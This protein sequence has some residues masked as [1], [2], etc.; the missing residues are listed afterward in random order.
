[1]NRYEALYRKG[2]RALVA[3]FAAWLGLMLI[4]WALPVR[5]Q[6]SDLIWG[7]IAVWFVALFVFITVWSIITMVSY[8]RWTG[9]YPYYFLF[10][11]SHDLNSKI[12][13]PKESSQDSH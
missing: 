13:K 10:R 12:D 7:V 6:K 3:S 1:M 9:R 2:T 11:A 4:A 8:I 5:A